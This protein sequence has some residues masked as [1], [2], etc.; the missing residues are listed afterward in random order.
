MRERENRR[1]DFGPPEPTNSRFAAAADADRSYRNDAPR[2]PPPTQNSRFAAMIEEDRADQLPPPQGPPPTQNSRFAAAA[3]EAEREQ[4]EREERRRERDNF[5]GRNEGPPMQQNSRFAAAVAADEDYVPE[6]RRRD[7]G[8]PLQDRFSD[9]DEGRY[10]GR[11]GGFDDGRSNSRFSSRGSGYDDQYDN[12][13]SG[14]DDRRTEQDNQFGERRRVDDILKPKERTLD[15]NILKA[16]ESKVHADNMFQVPK[17]KESAHSKNMLDIPAREEGEKKSEAHVAKLQESSAT[18]ESETG[19][20]EKDA[21]NSFADQ[22]KIIEELVSGARLGD[23]LKLWLTDQGPSALNIENLIFELLTEKEKKNPDPECGWAESSKYG[24]ALL[25]LVE[26]D[27]YGQMQI[28]W[29]I[30][31][32]SVF[33]VSL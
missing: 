8:P 23:D 7:R 29:G 2:G 33:T 16:P 22:E 26:E 10:D 25:S 18:V 9:R 4:S 27:V 13:W 19:T 1:R 15:D 14:Q 20:M 11:R 5:Y 21:S 3:A 31:K 17:G 6:E 30:Q 24:A 32:V 12:R 28:L